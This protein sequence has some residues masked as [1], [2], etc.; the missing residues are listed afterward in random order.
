MD[1]DPPTHLVVAFSLLTLVVVTGWIA[2]VR[3]AAPSDRR[4]RW[5]LGA[6]IAVA[7]W[8]ALHTG[9][10]LSGVIEGDR[11]PPPVLFYLA[12]T[13]LLGIAFATSKV[14]ARLAT[15]PLGLLVGF[16]AFRLPLEVILHELHGSGDLP[17]QMT[18][19]GL[20]FDVVTGLLAAVLGLVALRRELPTWVA[21]AFNVLGL[22]LLVVVVG[23][24]ITS[25]PTPLRRFL[26]GPPVVLPFHV[27]FHWIVSVHVWTALVGHI[28]LARALLARRRARASVHAL[29]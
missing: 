18:W 15:L 1:F 10:V 4:G 29:A 20:N 5:T 6:L 26:E 3:K 11:M 9:V 8:L 19:S 16:Q 23:I 27:P 24:A 12:P 25:A 13:M 2:V 7:A 28:I 21:A 14:G 17:I 22:T